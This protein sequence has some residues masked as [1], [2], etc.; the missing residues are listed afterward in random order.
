MYISVIFFQALTDQSAT[1][2]AK[3]KLEDLKDM[4]HFISTFRLPPYSY[5]WGTVKNYL[6]LVGKLGDC[7]HQKQLFVTPPNWLNTF[8]VAYGNAVSACSFHQNVENSEKAPDVRN[9]Y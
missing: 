7:V 6:T 2:M 5:S 3:S 1:S 4:D 8:K 9:L